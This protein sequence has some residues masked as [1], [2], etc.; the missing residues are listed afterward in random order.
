[1]LVELHR[2]GEEDRGGNILSLL[3]TEGICRLL[4]RLGRFFSC[5]SPQ[6]EWRNR[7]WDKEK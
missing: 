7:D 1:M 6:D 3:C 5:S 2:R 4:T